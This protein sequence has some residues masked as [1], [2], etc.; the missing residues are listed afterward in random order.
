MPPVPLIRPP[1]RA[2][3]IKDLLQKIAPLQRHRF[4]A[5]FIALQVHTSQPRY[6]VP[7]IEDAH[8][9]HEVRGM[10]RHLR[11]DP[12][13]CHFSHNVQHRG[14]QCRPQLHGTVSI[15]EGFRE[16]GSNPGGAN[17]LEREDA[18]GGEQVG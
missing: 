10:A 2:T 16:E 13:D 9:T 11:E 4:H 5:P 6:E 1:P 17:G 7:Q 12:S 3:L 18:L 15:G 14:Q 8:L